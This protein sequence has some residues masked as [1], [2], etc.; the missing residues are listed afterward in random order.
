MSVQLEPSQSEKVEGREL[1]G[2]Q[3]Q[4]DLGATAKS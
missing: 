4:S 3:S 1:S 2:C